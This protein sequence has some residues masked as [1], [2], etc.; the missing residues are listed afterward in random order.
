MKEAREAR[1][2]TQRVLFITGP[3]GAGRATTIHALEDFGYEAIDN[4]PLNLIPRLLAGPPPDHPLALGVDT[5]TRGFSPGRLLDLIDFM[6]EKER[7]QVEL[8][9]LD[10]RPGVLLRR[11]SETRR[12]H[13]L[14]PTE[15]PETGIARE[16]EILQP[17]RARANVLI[18]T[19]NMT[20]HDLRDEVKRLF[21]LPET[22]RMSVSVQSFSYKRGLPR[23]LDLV[24][25]VR[26]LRNPHWDPSL[27]GKTG[28]NPAVVAYIAE[29]ARFAE[30]IERLTGLLGFLLPAFEEEGKA[31]LAIG[32][33]C[34]GGQHRSVAIAEKV[35]NALAETGW[36]VSIR[37]NE[38]TRRAASAAE[39]H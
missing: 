14:A 19:S 16:I 9:F 2:S 6:G 4:L 33:G 15:S 30:F 38:L 35:A 18:D 11:Y 8:V 3:G 10:A 25:D 17:V 7:L 13:P 5:R 21:I 39:P 26:F 22:G 20:P 24:F 29:D 23:G 32:I 1:K 27:R 31:H 34:T 36:Q 37:H 12:R 28:E